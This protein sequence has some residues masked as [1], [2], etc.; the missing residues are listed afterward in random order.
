MAQKVGYFEDD[1]EFT[2]GPFVMVDA[3]GWR[4]EAELTGHKTSV[5]PH[6]SIYYFLEYHGY[7]AHKS[8][9][10]KAIAASVDFL[11]EQVRQGRIIKTTK[12]DPDDIF[13][14][15]VWVVNPVNKPNKDK[16]A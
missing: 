12:N 10:E 4:I 15:G 6:Y 16:T 3:G 2:E 1:F 13:V 7:Q 5:L 11:N 14:P 9:D 8:K